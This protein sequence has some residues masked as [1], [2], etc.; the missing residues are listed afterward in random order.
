VLG[1]A[2]TGGIAATGGGCV[3]GAGK[4]G[5]GAGAAGGARLIAPPDGSGT[6]AGGI[7]G[8]RSVNIWAETTAGVPKTR[9]KTSIA[10]AY[11]KARRLPRPD[12][13]M[14]LPP[15]VIR[16]LFTENAANSSLRS[17]L[18]ARRATSVKG[19]GVA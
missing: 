15:R 4:A 19:L 18:A 5:A 11:A 14:L 12:P 13:V 17:G 10:S 7:G 2:I 6:E 8:G 16:M 9:I 1:D 3:D